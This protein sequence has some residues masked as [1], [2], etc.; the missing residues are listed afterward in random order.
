VYKGFIPS[1]TLVDEAMFP[2]DRPGRRH[3]ILRGVAVRRRRAGALTFGL[4]L[5][6]SA[7]LVTGGV[8][9]GVAWA[10]GSSRSAGRKPIAPHPVV[11]PL[12]AIYGDSLVGQ[13]KPY[14]MAVGANLGMSVTVSAIGGTA[15]C[16]W[17]PT[18]EHDLTT[19]HI[20]VVVWAFSGNSLTPCMRTGPTTFIAGAAKVAKYKVDTQAAID[21][22]DKAGALFVVASPPAF[23]TA[24]DGWDLLDTMYRGLAFANPT[25][26]YLDGGAEIA[27]DGQF[28]A[29][30]TCLPFERAVP[31]SGCT[32][33]ASVI[34]VR[35]QDGMHFCQVGVGAQC[36]GYSSG[37][38]RYAIN[39]LS[40]ARLDFD[41]AA[42]TSA[43][44]PS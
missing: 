28:M 15:P 16:D 6:Y 3:G 24:G 27:P 18:L 35:G 21:A 39:L 43:R 5:L 31:Q 8:V 44:P 7:V 19:E 12:V 36:D 37:A 29:D 42:S 13:A 10:H 20:A 14:L 30:Q 23:R 25:V 22:V 33:P 1:S 40:G 26:Q 38:L 34:A 41:H 32:G 11:V 4:V 9:A 17:L 2:D